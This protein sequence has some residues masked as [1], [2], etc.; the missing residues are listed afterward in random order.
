MYFKTIALPPIQSYVIMEVWLN[1]IWVIEW[2]L[3]KEHKE[4][5]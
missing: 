2:Y 5:C 4:N 3:K 1:S